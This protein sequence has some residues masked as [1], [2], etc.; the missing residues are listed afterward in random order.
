MLASQQ[1]DM[2]IRQQYCGRCW[3]VEH[4]ER[5]AME[6]CECCRARLNGTEADK[7]GGLCK[8]CAQ[9]Y[10]CKGKGCKMTFCLACT[11]ASF[12]G[13]LWCWCPSCKA[14]F[15]PACIHATEHL[16][17]CLKQQ[18]PKSMQT[19]FSASARGGDQQEQV[20]SAA[21]TS[22]S[23][24]SVSSSSSGAMALSADHRTA[25]P[26]ATPQ[27]NQ[28]RQSDAKEAAAKPSAQK[29]VKEEGRRI[30]FKRMFGIEVVRYAIAEGIITRM[31][32][33]ERAAEIISANL[34]PITKENVK[35]ARQ[36]LRERGQL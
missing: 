13:K 1:Q 17:V 5:I 9:V 23:T 22:A 28:Q 15:C 3:H 11:D 25:A 10:R 20:G 21:A 8:E 31:D 33:N 19:D 30:D 14:I 36:R 35:K 29:A 2:S 26:E 27:V 7:A 32:T 16:T 34:V 4:V 12:E 18:Q 24:S 6:P